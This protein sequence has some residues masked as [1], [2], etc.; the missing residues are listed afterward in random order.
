MATLLQQRDEEW[1]E[2]L[3]KRDKALRAKLK[4]KER[5]FANDQI[6]R[7]EELIRIMVIR[8]KYMEKNL[9]HKVEAF[10]YLYKEY[11]KEIKVLILERDEELKHSLGYRDKLWTNSI[12][13]VNSN[14]IKMHQAQG[15]FE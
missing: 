11:Q 5:A 9:L 4:E 10:G 1:K 12:D 2:E 8:E 13:Q 14:M 3:A 7:D 6:M 15:E